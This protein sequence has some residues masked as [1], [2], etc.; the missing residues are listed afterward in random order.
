[1]LGALGRQR[2]YVWWITLIE[3]AV[4]IP[5]IGVTGRFR[6]I[7]VVFALRLLG[8]DGYYILLSQSCYTGCAQQTQ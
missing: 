7:V 5:Y 1:M 3:E 8:C 6:A 2:S 4:L